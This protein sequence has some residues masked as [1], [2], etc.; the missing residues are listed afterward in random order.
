MALTDTAIKA[1]KPATKP[2]RLFDERGLYLL[3]DPR[4]GR[5]WRLKYRV[6]GREKLLAI[7]AY[8]DL[9]L[10]KA[11]ERREEARGLLNQQI[12]PGARKKAERVA[13]ADTFE[14]IAREWLA[15]QKRG[16]AEKTFLR[17]LGWFE[18][19]LF[20][21]LGRH[22]IAK[23]T[24]PD[25]L[26]ALKRIEARG[27]RETAH[28]ARSTASNVFRYAVATGRAER[29]ITT[30]LR[31]AL[32]PV[33]TTHR[34][35][36]TVPVQIGQLMRTIYAYRGQR[37]TEAA[38]KLAPLFF[39]RPTELRAA[40]WPEFDLSAE[41]PEWRI[42]ASRMKMAEEHIVPLADQAMAILR[43]LV[44]I[45]GDG[46]YVFPSLRGANR[47]LSENTVNF[48]LR[49]MGYSGD[50][51]TGHGF[52]AMAS[53]CLNEQGFPPDVIELQLAHAERNEVRAAYNRAKRIPE[54]RAMMQSWANFL[55]KLR[56][57]ETTQRAAE[58]VL[59]T[60]WTSAPIDKSQLVEKIES[61]Q[62]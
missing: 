60:N 39:V 38:L 21:Y 25:L 9:S 46:R 13:Q 10:A 33:V 16:L 8:P 4:G 20:P 5:L 17:K 37:P 36:I 3:V 26:A 15:L 28:R 19:F 58:T 29:D 31:G 51:I 57:G 62:T 61:L 59:L 23:I 43:D 42:P 1:A 18:D 11:R 40:E 32:A 6:D 48:A 30:D 49:S 34:A 45:T 52:R 44:P 14:S 53:T 27:M 2:Y 35:A 12:D 55:D 22:P 54:R 50:Q 24:V 47:P 7:G 41:H 56:L